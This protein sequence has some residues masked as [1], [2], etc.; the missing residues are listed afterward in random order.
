M[1]QAE[2]VVPEG[3]RARSFW[4]EL[5]IR[6]FTEKRL[7]AAGAV[8]VVVLLALGVFAQFLAPYA[9][10]ATLVCPRLAPPSGEHVLGCDQ[11]GRDL[12]SRIIYGARISL[13]IGLS[14]GVISVSLSTVIGTITGFFG[15]ALD[16]I[17]QRFIDAWMCVPGLMVMLTL[18][19]VV[20]PGMLTVI[21]ILG[22]WFAVG[23]SR[24]VRGAVMGVKTNTYVEA[25][26]AI[27]CRA[28]RIILR[29]ILP[30]VA[31][32]MIILF[33]LSVGGAIMYEALMSFL[34]LGVPPPA[35]SWGGMLSDAGRRY[36]YAAPHLALWPGLF[37]AVVIYGINVLGDAFRDLLDPRLRGGLGR[38]D[39]A[40]KRLRGDAERG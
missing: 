38:Y 37:L 18:A 9:Y 29:H 17:V 3:P 7:G 15:G 32:P 40:V 10:D 26:R 34:G 20:G 12:L 1:A 2:L 14:V 35:P 28:G 8:I 16:M 21:L 36:M 11:L 23:Q 22:F 33:T 5:L 13:I 30:N 6:L 25:A 19:S 27:G 24:I 31:A 39:V 4:A